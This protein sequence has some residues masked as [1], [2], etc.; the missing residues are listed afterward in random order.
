M[1]GGRAGRRG[2]REP[3]ARARRAVLRKCVC[4]RA[5]A[6]NMCAENAHAALRPGRVVMCARVGGCSGPAGGC[7]CPQHGRLHHGGH[8]HQDREEC[9][10]ERA[11]VRGAADTGLCVCARGVE[12]GDTV[13]A[14]DV[15]LVLET[16]KAW[17][18][19]LL[20]L[21]WRANAAVQV[22]VDVRAPTAG[23]I[24]EVLAAKDAVVKGAFARGSCVRACVWVCLCV[25]ACVCMWV[26]TCVRVFVSV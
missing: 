15:V 14:D 19:L 6:E 24:V 13:N 26:R 3:R 10:A 9:A 22:S 17:L 12:A 4:C 8:R 7:E 23:T 2:A 21:L 20:L 18:M 11:R 1:C 16:D 25:Y 5:R